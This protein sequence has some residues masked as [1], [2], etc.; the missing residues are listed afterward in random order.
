VTNQN[1]SIVLMSSAI[2]LAGMIGVGVAIHQSGVQIPL[3]FMETSGND[4]PPS[5]PASEPA[6]TLERRPKRLEER[7]AE[8]VDRLSNTTAG[9]ITSQL[10]NEVNAA[11][12]NSKTA[13]G[14]F[15]QKKLNE[16]QTRLQ[17][18]LVEGLKSKSNEGIN[19]AMDAAL[20]EVDRS[21]A[22]EFQNIQLTPQQQSQIQQARQKMQSDAVRILQS[23]PELVLEQLKNSDIKPLQEALA[24]PLRT[25]INTIASTLTPEQRQKWQQNFDALTQERRS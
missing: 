16:Q 23:N 15:V 14:Q 11:V 22:T 17:Q 4:R 10:P 1:K 24:V 12:Q 3:S 2:A 21:I 9:R 6:P 8:L 5:Q 19:S 13:I 7:Q 25:Y 18:A 20:A